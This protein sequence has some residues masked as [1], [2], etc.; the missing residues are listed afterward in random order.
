MFMIF[1]FNLM[2]TETETLNLYNKIQNF[3]FYNK[4]L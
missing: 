1:L 3:E 4:Y 2:N